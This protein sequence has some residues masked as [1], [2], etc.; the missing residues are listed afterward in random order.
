MKLGNL[1]RSKKE[2]GKRKKE[3][4]KKTQYFFLKRLTISIIDCWQILIY[5]G[6]EAIDIKD[7]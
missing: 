3:D 5:L 4:G 2:D 1:K 6:K 7:G